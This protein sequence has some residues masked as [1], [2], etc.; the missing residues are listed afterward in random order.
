MGAYLFEPNWTDATKLAE[1]IAKG[2]VKDI[3]DH[4][5]HTIVLHDCWQSA[6]VVYKHSKTQEVGRTDHMPIICRQL[7]G[8]LTGAK[9]AYHL[10]HG[11][12][13]NIGNK[14][15]VRK[16]GM[17]RTA[18]ENGLKNSYEY[19]AISMVEMTSSTQR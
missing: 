9:R 10:Y 6:K 5:F 14:M 4:L 18:D 1:V 13:S 17:E 3:T 15:P 2:I 7:D 16:L 12:K 11:R 19:K 8:Q